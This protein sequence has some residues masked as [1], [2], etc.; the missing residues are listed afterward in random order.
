MLKCQWKHK[1]KREN[2]DNNKG[3]EWDYTEAWK[4]CLRLGSGIA[5]YYDL[6]FYLF[7]IV[8]IFIWV[9]LIA[10]IVFFSKCV[11]KVLL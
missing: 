11:H 8:F 2:K 1:G 5:V 3:D 4:L 10:L 9:N 6:I 7:S